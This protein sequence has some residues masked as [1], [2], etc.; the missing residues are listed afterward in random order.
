MFH[1]QAKG[2]SRFNEKNGANIRNR[3]MRFTLSEL[4]S[5][6]T[7]VMLSTYYVSLGQRLRRRWSL[8]PWKTLQKAANN[9]KAG[10]IVHVGAGTYN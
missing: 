6:E 8:R 10:D 7:R 9:A 5:L 1:N 4:E 2:P 3:G